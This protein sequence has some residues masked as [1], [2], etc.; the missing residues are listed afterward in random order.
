MKRSSLEQ[1]FFD[2]WKQYGRGKIPTEQYRFHPIRK[3]RFDFAWP[4]LKVAIELDGFGRGRWGGHQT[5]KGMSS[6]YEKQNLAIEN[7][8]VV[9]RY[10]DRMLSSK[11]KRQL[12]CEQILRIL[13]SRK[14]Q[15]P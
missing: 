1:K 5:H 8:W 3:F 4:R 15:S 11:L 7:G 10:T 9:L 12:A 14:N 13:S 2:A 6:G